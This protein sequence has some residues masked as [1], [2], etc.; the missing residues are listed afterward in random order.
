MRHRLA[1]IALVLAW[2]APT[3]PS[4]RT[5]C[6]GGDAGACVLWGVVTVA[7]RGAP[8]EG[9][10]GRLEGQCSLGRA[11]AC[12]VYAL[13]LGASRAPDARAGAS[14]ALERACSLGDGD[15]CID[16]ALLLRGYRGQGDPGRGWPIMERACEAGHARW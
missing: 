11:R 13:V 2:T 9:L 3:D 6:E 12:G 7:Q 15:A 1:W 4:A 14:A 16:H 10:A 8:P 5:G